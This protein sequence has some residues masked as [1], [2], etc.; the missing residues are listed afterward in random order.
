MLKNLSYHSIFSMNI[1]DLHTVSSRKMKCRWFCFH[2][3]RDFVG[4]FSLSLFLALLSVPFLSSFL[5]IL[6]VSLALLVLPFV[7]LL[8]AA[9]IGRA[10]SSTSSL[11][12]MQRRCAACATSGSPAIGRYPRTVSRP[13]TPRWYDGRHGALRVKLAARPAV[14]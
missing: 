3:S 9:S 10:G 7:F 8:T 12:W 5:P 4:G 13:K 14:L 6:S 2:F 1:M 11:D